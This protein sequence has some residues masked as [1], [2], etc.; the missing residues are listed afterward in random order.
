MKIP[1]EAEWPREYHR[2]TVAQG[3]IDDG[4]DW[5]KDVPIKKNREIRKIFRKKNLSNLLFGDMFQKGKGVVRDESQGL[6]WTYI[7]WMLV[8]STETGEPEGTASLVQEE[9]NGVLALEFEVQSNYSV[10]KWIYLL[11]RLDI[12]D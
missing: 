1:L 3:R 7:Q 11:G 10:S 4:F 5:I 2:V 8:L 12:Q 9:K 6:A